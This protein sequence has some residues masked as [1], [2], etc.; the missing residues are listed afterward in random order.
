MFRDNVSEQMKKR[1]RD[2]AVFIFYHLLYGWYARDR[3]LKDP[4]IRSLW[5]AW[6][7]IPL[8]EAVG[9]DLG[10]DNVDPEILFYSLI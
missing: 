1:T 10:L 2:T 8:L 9:T 6:G 7:F 5:D 3:P 4:L